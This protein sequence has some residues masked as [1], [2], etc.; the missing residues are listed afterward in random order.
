MAEVSCERVD[1]NAAHVSDVTD[2]KRD[3][4]QSDGRLTRVA[5]VKSMMHVEEHW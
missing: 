1:R 4:A 2:Y 3:T 5:Y